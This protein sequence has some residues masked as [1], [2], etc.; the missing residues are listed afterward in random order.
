MNFH[1]KVWNYLKEQHSINLRSCERLVFFVIPGP[2]LDDSLEL[3]L[4]VDVGEA[5]QLSELLPLKQGH[6][7][8]TEGIAATT[9]EKARQ[10]QLFTGQWCSANSPDLDS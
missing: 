6:D 3:V 1:H 2:C 5:G 4:H 9:L 10:I 8:L 7:E